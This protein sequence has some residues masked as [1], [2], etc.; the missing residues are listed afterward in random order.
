MHCFDLHVSFYV[1][2][3]ARQEKKKGF[4]ALKKKF[5]CPFIEKKTTFMLVKRDLR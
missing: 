2:L 3:Y 4:F 5:D 1:I